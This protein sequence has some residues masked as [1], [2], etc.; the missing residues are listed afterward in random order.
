[1][2]PSG[3]CIYRGQQRMYIRCVNTHKNTSWPNNPSNCLICLSIYHKT[4]SHG[5][6]ATEKYYLQHSLKKK[7]RSEK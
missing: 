2:L 5:K 7:R 6:K 4:H 1:M 3:C